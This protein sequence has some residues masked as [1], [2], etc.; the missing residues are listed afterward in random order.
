M[1][2]SP[3]RILRIGVDATL[4]ECRCAVLGRGGYDAQPAN[5]AD[6]N[7]QLRSSN[8]DPVIVSSRMVAEQRTDFYAALPAK[9]PALLLERF[10]FPME[11]QSAVAQKLERAG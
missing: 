11:M 9:A 4:V 10:T 1:A 2:S 8:F 5:P 7:Q 6:A 3:S